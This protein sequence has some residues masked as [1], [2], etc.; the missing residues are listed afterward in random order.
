MLA[1]W[2]PGQFRFC[3]RCLV[4]YEAVRSNEFGKLVTLDREGRSSAMSVLASSVLRSLRA[5]DAPDFPDEARKLLTFVDNRQDASLQAGHF[6][7]FALVVQLRAALHRALVE[8]GEGGLEAL[9]L[10]AE[11]TAALALQPDDY[12]QAPAAVVGRQRASRALRNVVEYRA[13]RDLQRGWRIT[14]P[15]LEQTGLL[16]VDYPDLTVLAGLDELWS[17][18]H[19]LLAN[20]APGRRTEIGQ[21]L[22]DE[23]RRFLAIDAPALTADNVD[24]LR[25]ES[26]EQLEGLWTVPDTE[27]DPPLGLAIAGTGGKSRPRNALYLSGRGAFGRWLRHQDRFGAP[28]SVAEADDVI[29]SLLE[30]LHSQG[31]LVQATEMG[32]TGYRLNSGAMTLRAGAGESGAADPLRRRFTA[33]NRPRVIPFFKELYLEG[34]RQLAGLRAAEHTAQVSPEDRQDRERLFG[35]TPRRCRCCSAPRRWSW[36]STFAR[37]TPSRCAMCPR[38]RR[39]TPSAAVAPAGRG[40]PH[41]SSPTVPAAT[42]TTRTTSSVPIRWWPVVCR[43][44]GWIWPM[45]TWC[46]PTSMPCGWPRRAARW[47][48]PWPMSCGSTI[49]RSRSA[50]RCGTRSPNPTPPGARN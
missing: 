33:E 49:R 34:G 1:A 4:S 2:I 42:P 17:T 39:T 30:F 12:A 8:A 29:H 31:L 3:L 40:S 7:D 10:G 18:V 44:R 23:M 11:V 6:N 32:A 13:V 45:R 14:L 46:V 26:H 22:F 25:R 28:L 16:V 36:A 19:P 38:P 43:P 35:A 27:P 48:V 5:I 15:N 37:S 9:D 20:A 41:S 21:V 50:T 24:R 47:V